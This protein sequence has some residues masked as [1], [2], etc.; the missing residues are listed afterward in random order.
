MTHFALHALQGLG[1]SATAI[2]GVLG[3]SLM[4]NKYARKRA[5]EPN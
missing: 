3:Y 5:V 2:L 1:G 4:K